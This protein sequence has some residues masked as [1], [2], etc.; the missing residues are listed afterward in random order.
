M[1]KLQYLN[2][3][4][5]R[6]SNTLETIESEEGGT[7]KSYPCITMT[8]KDSPARLDDLL[9]LLIVPFI[10]ASGFRCDAL[11]TESELE[12]EINKRLIEEK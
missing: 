2:E 5:P 3:N 6:N 10:E 1:F 11:Y 8:L 12:E 4:E 9:D 7:L